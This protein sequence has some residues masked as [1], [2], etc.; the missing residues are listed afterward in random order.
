MNCDFIKPHC[1]APDKLKLTST[2][3][4]ANETALLRKIANGEVKIG[5]VSDVIPGKNVKQAQSITITF[6]P[7]G[8]D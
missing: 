5:M 1:A 2:T 7:V 4:A 8:I 3:N 6:V